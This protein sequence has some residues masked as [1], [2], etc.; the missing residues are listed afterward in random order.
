M[1]MSIMNGF[2]SDEQDAALMKVYRSSQTAKQYLV[3]NLPN[4]GSS[5]FWHNDET[6]IAISNSNGRLLLEIFEGAA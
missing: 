1:S 4:H 5:K 2:I 3:E 6:G